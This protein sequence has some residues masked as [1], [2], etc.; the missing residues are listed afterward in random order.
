MPE[1]SNEVSILMA[2]SWQ[3]LA[4]AKEPISPTILCDCTV[5]ILFASFFIE[6][7]LNHFL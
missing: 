3:A 1:V 6:A 2:T 7:N 5:T 4:R